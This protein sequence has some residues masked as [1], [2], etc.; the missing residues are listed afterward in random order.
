MVMT[1]IEVSRRSRRSRALLLDRDG[2]INVDHGYVHRIQDFEFVPGIFDLVRAAH[3]AHFQVIVITNQAGI[4]RGFYS[5]K[6]FDELTGWMCKEFES[7]GAPI[8]KVYF[9][10]YHPTEGLGRYR[11]DDVSRKPHPG[12]ILQ[13]QTEF[14]LGLASSI[15]IGD[16]ASDIRAGIAAGVGQNIL[17]ASSDPHDLRGAVYRRISCLD[18]ALALFHAGH[19][20]KAAP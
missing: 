1:S 20:P 7:R 12:M 2:V 16:K 6:Q 13:A 4:A 17:L 15:L 9:S 8:A 5:E 14:D 19:P 3:H 18:E 11:K 10:P